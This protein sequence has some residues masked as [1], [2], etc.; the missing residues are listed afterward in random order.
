MFYCEWATGFSICPG[1]LLV[2]DTL[3][4]KQVSQVATPQ[5]HL[6]LRKGPEATLA[7]HTKD[8]HSFF[9]PGFLFVW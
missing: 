6:Q 5:L 4:Y 1:F 2:L 7:L 3:C 8:S 9:D